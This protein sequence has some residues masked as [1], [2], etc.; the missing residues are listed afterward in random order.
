MIIWG[1]T[2]IWKSIVFT[3]GLATTGFQ[4]YSKRIVV[5]DEMQIKNRFWF[6]NRNR[7]PDESVIL[8]AILL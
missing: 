7:G 4:K 8:D 1:G 2:F 3:T 5:N 6:M